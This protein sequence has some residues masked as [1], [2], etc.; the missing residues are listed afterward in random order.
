MRFLPVGLD[1]RNRPCTVVG[2]GAVG[3]RKALT[4]ARAG[5]LVTVVAPEVTP[6]LAGEIGA[7]RIRWIRERFRPD[8]VTD[9]FLAVMA[10]DDPDLNAAGIQLAAQRGVLACDASSAR[11]SRLIFGALLESDDVTIATF[12]DGRDPTLARDTRDAIAELLGRSS[13]GNGNGKKRLVRDTVL[14]LAA[15]GSRNRLWG[16]PLETLTADIQAALGEENVRL[17]YVQF[18][19]PPLESAVAEAAN[20][21]AR[22]VRVLPLFMTGEGHVERDIRPLIRRMRDAYPHLDL[23]LLAP[24]GESAAFR[25]ALLEIARETIS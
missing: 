16:A 6:E 9:A 5:A 20:A 23:E 15:H 7:G 25:K 8:H 18:G 11:H 4:L 1:T 17:A 22:A 24:V 10:T 2:G 3:T 12:T 13:D 21:G 14:I 19:T